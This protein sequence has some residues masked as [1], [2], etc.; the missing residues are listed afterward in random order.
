MP[1][2]FEVPETE[3]EKPVEEPV[4]EQNPEMVAPLPDAETIRRIQEEEAAAR[5]R[6]AQ[7]T[8]LDT[9][10]EALMALA[11][12]Y[13]DAVSKL[14]QVIQT[15]RTQRDLAEA[16]RMRA[17]FAAHKR[18]GAPIEYLEEHSATPQQLEAA[19]KA[20]ESQRHASQSQPSQPNSPMAQYPKQI[21]PSRQVAPTVGRAPKRTWGDL[22]ETD[23]AVLIEQAKKGK[24]S[25]QDLP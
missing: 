17:I 24:L 19:V 11:K 12:E 6:S 1:E 10:N 13:P 7:G 20:Y 8:D 5:M 9:V 23:M 15:I 14:Q 16:E 18:T 21:P 25:R 4:E 22:S 3:E 2:D